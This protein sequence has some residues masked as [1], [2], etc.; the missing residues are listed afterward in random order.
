MGLYTQYK[1]ITRN[2]RGTWFVA[3]TNTERVVGLSTVSLRQSGR[4]Q[5]DGFTHQLF[6]K[7][8]GDLISTAMKWGAE[9]G[10]SKVLATVSIEDEDKQ[11][12]MESLGFRKDKAGDDFEV[13]GR[14]VASIRME[15]S[16]S[17]L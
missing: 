15:R 16:T 13:D 17:G 9:N 2:G 6:S 1:G 4:C 7:C 10:A 14:A 3:C 8:R 5:V 11:T 12:F